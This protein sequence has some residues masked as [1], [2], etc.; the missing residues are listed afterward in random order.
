[1]MHFLKNQNVS[2]KNEWWKIRPISD[3]DRELI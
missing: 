3:L 2:D 1:M